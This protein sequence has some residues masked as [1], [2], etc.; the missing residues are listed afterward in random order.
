VKGMS[1]PVFYGT[2][3]LGATAALV[4]MQGAGIR[5]IAGSSME[6]TLPPGAVVWVSPLRGIV[7]GRGDVVVAFGAWGT[8]GYIVKRVTGVSGDCVPIA[9]IAPVV[10]PTD[11][12]VPC[13]EVRQH[14]YFLTGDNRA[15]SVDSRQKGLV[16]SGA[17]IGS[18]S[19]VVWPLQ[20]V[21]RP[22]PLQ[23]RPI[24]HLEQ[25]YVQ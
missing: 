5:M 8:D 23:D 21:G 1:R 22:L 18:V 4:H 17:I 24:D 25:A 12:S 7:P 6:P 16:K 10:Q 11:A 15:A 19:F 9:E 20:R 3:L 14:A 2:V 13:L